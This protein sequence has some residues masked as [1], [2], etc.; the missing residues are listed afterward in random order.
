MEGFS[1]NNIFDTKG[2]EYLIIISFLL[3]IIPFWIIINRRSAQK[4]AAGILTAGNISIP[5][6]IFYSKNHTWAFLEKSGTA[7]VGLNDFLIHATGEIRVTG[8]KPSGTVITKGELLAAIA[9]TGK[10]LNIFSPVSGVIITSN[11]TL[12]DEPGIINEDPY[13]N[14]WVYKIKPS[15]WKAETSS[16]YLAEEAVAWFKNELSRFRDFLAH[17]AG[18]HSPEGS[19]IIL[20]DGG[21]I[22]DNPLRELPEEV[23]KDFQKSFLN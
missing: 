14:G 13:G 2:I 21:E 6:G 23:W 3:L 4:K 17:S 5:Q 11:S 20:Q 19:V 16:Y 9:Q 22:C 15:D 8:L 18:I 7:R 12:I 10:R 1:Y